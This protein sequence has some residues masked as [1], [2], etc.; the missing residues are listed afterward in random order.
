MPEPELALVGWHYAKDAVFHVR[1]IKPV[2][3]V[4]PSIDEAATLRGT[5][6][7]LVASGSTPYYFGLELERVLPKLAGRY[8]AVPVLDDPLLW[9]FDP[10]AARR[11]GEGRE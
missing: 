1:A 5:L 11:A 2:V 3:I 9:R 4:D 8:R 10:R 7:A 6:D